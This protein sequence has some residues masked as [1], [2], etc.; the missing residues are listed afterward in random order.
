M[1]NSDQSYLQKSLQQFEEHPY[2]N[3]PIEVSPKD[4]PQLLYEGSLVTARYRR[5]GRVITDLENRVMLDVACGTGATTLA[6]A[7]A[8]P[9]AKIIG[10]DISPESIKIAEQ[11]LKYHGF[12][13]VSFQ[14]LA[15][16]ELEQLGL[17][18]DYIGSKDI[19]YLLPDQ[20]AALA[21]M[22]NVLKP[23]GIIRSNLHS[24]YQ[25]QA[26]Y[27]AQELFKLMGLVEDNPGDME[28]TI[29]REFFDSLK[30]G[31]N[32]KLGA[33]GN[34]VD[35]SNDSVLLSNH[36]II[37]DKGFT[38]P[39]L[40]KFIDAA[41]LEF[42]DMVDWRNW[43]L[44]NLFKEPDNLSSY[45]ALSL[46]G[47]G[48]QEQLSLYELVQP[49]KRL[50]DFWCGHPQAEGKSLETD[51]QAVAPEKLRVHFHPCLKKESFCQAV[52][53]EN[54]LIPLNLG[55][56]FTFLIG[57][58]AWV[59]RTLISAVF[60]PLLEAPRSLAFLAERWLQIC[61]VNPITLEPT[62]REQAVALLRA[63]V[64]DQEKLG[65]FLLE[66]GD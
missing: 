22:A 7:L 27:R 34:H 9:G 28:M 2:P 49:D 60:A 13:E 10:V 12:E 55:A 45:V 64:L 61:P 30:D 25:R 44:A 39:H 5:D 14:V 66:T 63:A 18:F 43:N 54:S 24:Y 16:E 36:L 6:M 3:I 41:G 8:N 29:V 23:D 65:I 57:K 21:Q 47:L 17:R 20:G 40:F 1:I 53:E 52:W 56:F 15:L 51:W 26:F 42:I 48:A 38:I 37:N 62:V 33:W 32:L 35:K 31:I 11:R 19:L 59:D 58:D 50:L 46:A 4:N